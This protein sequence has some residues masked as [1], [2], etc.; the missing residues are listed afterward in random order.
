MLNRYFCQLRLFPT[1]FLIAENE[2]RSLV[3]TAANFVF[4]FSF[5][6]VEEVV[7]AAPRLQT[8]WLI[9]VMFC[10]EWSVSVQ[11]EMN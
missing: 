7:R 10:I 9:C 8:I 6:W 3:F 4:F 1:E 5:V 11:N 2:K